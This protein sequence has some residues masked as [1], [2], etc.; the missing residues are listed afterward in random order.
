[1]P[2]VRPHLDDFTLLRFVV[3]DVT[4]AERTQVRS[5]VDDCLKCNATLA[6]LKKVDRGLRRLAS[7]GLFAD[8]SDTLPTRDPFR[9]R[10]RAPAPKPGSTERS[11]IPPDTVGIAS[12]AVALQK[13][14]RESLVGGR[15]RE[16]VASLDLEDP[17][18]RFA[19]LYS[20]QESG[21][22]ITE[23]PRQALAFAAETIRRLRGIPRKAT[24]RAPAERLVPWESLWGHAHL[25]AAKAYLWTKEFDRAEPS[26]RIAYRAFG[27]VGDETNLAIVEFTESQRRSFV[28]QGRA[29]LVLAIRA[30]TTFEDRGL[31]DLAARATVAEGLA[32]FDLDEREE[33]VAAYR[34][35]LPVFERYGLWSNYV[36]ALNS[37]ATSLTSLGRLDEARGEYARAL[38]R[39]S[40]KD[41]RS[42]QGF[43]RIGL[44]EIL[45]SAGRFHQAALSAGAAGRIFSD[46]GMRANALI[47]WLFE[48]E[49]WARHGDLGRARARLDAFGEAARLEKAIDPSVRR[50]LETALRATRLDFEELATL[51]SRLDEQLL[52]GSADR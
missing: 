40:G 17:E 34:K 5:H 12:R 4:P 19:L 46:G 35:A 44:A 28:K 48:V 18:H 21:R 29:A 30:R 23:S 1:M 36:G 33:S 20:L 9:R 16:A 45:Q 41:H 31:D 39:F 11:R 15:I 13:R 22:L 25:L 42:W 50:Q 32:L 52:G 47:V 38:R 7:E 43:L 49:C 2:G 37:I 24:A 10:P 8:L 51:R 27:S 26:L 14:V 3:G 6:E